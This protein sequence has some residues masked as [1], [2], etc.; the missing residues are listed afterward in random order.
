MIPF[1][2]E[3][4]VCF[5]K[6]FEA[7][8]LTTDISPNT[9]WRLNNKL[10]NPIPTN[11]QLGCKISSRDD[12]RNGLKPSIHSTNNKEKKKKW[13]SLPSVDVD[14]AELNEIGGSNCHIIL[15]KKKNWTI[16]S[17]KWFAKVFSSSISNLVQ[18][19]QRLLQV[20]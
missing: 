12:V 5:S 19:D 7:H 4:N 10:P 17:E 2:T 14:V 13:D 8:R 6:P 3:D 11:N 1:S 18:I 15:S 20:Q 16:N 9:Q